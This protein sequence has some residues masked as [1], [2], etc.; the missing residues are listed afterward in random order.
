MELERRRRDQQ[1]QQQRQERTP[2]MRRPQEPDEWAPSRSELKVLRKVLNHYHSD[3]PSNAHVQQHR[4][5]YREANV[6]PKHLARDYEYEAP[7]HHSS[8]RHAHT[9]APAP[10]PEIHEAPRTPPHS[11]SHVQPQAKQSPGQRSP[12]TG[13]GH[14]GGGLSG[15]AGFSG[16]KQ[17][18]AIPMQGHS[19]QQL[20]DVLVQL[21]QEKS[22]KED[23]IAK[24]NQTKARSIADR[25]HRMATEQRI[26]SLEKEINKNKTQLRQL[27]RR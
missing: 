7:S 24:L 23:E 17:Q 9:H 5:P 2:D 4:S 6:Q 21:H 19:I 22:L 1:Q 18:V 25:K 13:K 8:V 10:A 15:L 14:L 27:T 11:H 26:Q 3:A 12:T 20:E 16:G